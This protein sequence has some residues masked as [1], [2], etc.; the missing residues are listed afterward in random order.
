M[1]D[2]EKLIPTFSNM[3]TALTR[4][5]IKVRPK[6]PQSIASIILTDIYLTIIRPPSD[7]N[8]SYRDNFN[9]Y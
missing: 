4:K 2:I 6:L 3:K 5:K 7:L 1:E 8:T 9:F